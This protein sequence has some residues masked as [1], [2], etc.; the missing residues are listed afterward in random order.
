MATTT[1]S[2]IN[3]VNSYSDIA[4]KQSFVFPIWGIGTCTFTKGIPTP[5][6]QITATTHFQNTKRQ[7]R[8][9]SAGWS[10]IQTGVYHTK[11]L[12]PDKS[13]SIRGT[14]HSRKWT[15]GVGSKEFCLTTTEP[16]YFNQTQTSGPTSLSRLIFRKT[17]PWTLRVT[18]M[19][20][21]ETRVGI[22]QSG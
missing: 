6:W 19:T 15:T 11:N 21:R 9:H 17:M 18:R 2:Y 3:L 14:H 7:D 8:K 12:Y 13:H 20:L 5:N 10:S 1:P 16:K 22:S 4:V